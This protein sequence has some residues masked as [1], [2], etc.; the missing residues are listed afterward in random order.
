MAFFIMYSVEIAMW[1]YY[2]NSIISGAAIT[3]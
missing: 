2:W 1:V 3:L